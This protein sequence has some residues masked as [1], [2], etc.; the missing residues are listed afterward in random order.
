MQAYKHMVS[1]II[2]AAYSCGIMAP[3]VEQSIRR[4]LSICTISSKDKRDSNSPLAKSNLFK[5]ARRFI[6]AKNESP[7][8]PI[9]WE[10]IACNPK[11]GRS[12]ATHPSTPNGTR[13]S[14]FF[15]SLSNR[16]P[17]TL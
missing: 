2:I 14:A 15:T 8:F 4:P 9:L 5:T 10:A 16:A 12:R 3:V 11:I 13:P 6:K 7:Y 1:A 17:P